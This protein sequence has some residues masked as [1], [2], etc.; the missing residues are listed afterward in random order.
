MAECRY[1]D[2]NISLNI[3]EDLPGHF[4]GHMTLTGVDGSEDRKCQCGPTR[5]FATRDLATEHA[6]ELAHTIIDKDWPTKKS[7]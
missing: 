3:T 1:K 7:R 2:V 6:V 5:Y 4:G